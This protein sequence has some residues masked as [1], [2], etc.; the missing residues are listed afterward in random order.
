MFIASAAPAMAGKQ[1]ALADN[2]REANDRFKDV[3]VATAEG[4]GPIPCASGPTGGAM[5]IHY[6]NGA[7]LEDGE[8]E[9]RS[10]RPSCT[11][12]KRTGRSN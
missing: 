7:Y 2:V 12:P 6:V 3:S 11:S 10:L 1:N 8:I 9:S 4:Y 5:G